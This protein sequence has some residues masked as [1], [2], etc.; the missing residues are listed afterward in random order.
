MDRWG[1]F[2]YYSM[3]NKAD[4]FMSLFWVLSLHFYSYSLDLS[5]G[6]QERCQSNRGRSP[7]GWTSRLNLSEG[8]QK[9]GVAKATMWFILKKKERT[10]QLSNTKRRQRPQKITKVHNHKFFP[11]LKKPK[12][13]QISQHL[14]IT[15]THSKRQANQ[16][17]SLHSRDTFMNGNAEVYS[18]V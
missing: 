6:G 5:I 8:E 3:T 9:L 11:W 13:N 2:P 15:T 4:T 7:S 18:K 10:D 1:L 17:Q 12:S 16:C 14:T